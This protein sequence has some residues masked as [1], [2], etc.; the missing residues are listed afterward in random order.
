MLDFLQCVISAR[1]FLEDHI[2]GI[3][4]ISAAVV[5]LLTIPSAQDIPK[6]ATPSPTL[7]VA[8]ETE[9]TDLQRSDGLICY[10]G[11]EL[12]SPTGDLSF[13]ALYFTVGQYHCIQR[14]GSPKRLRRAM[15]D[16]STTKTV[17]TLLA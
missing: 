4:R 16:P 6:A 5:V 1:R 15:V 14:Y 11:K 13:Q 7:E 9:G 12:I 10:K 17:R 2:S 8:N 3:T